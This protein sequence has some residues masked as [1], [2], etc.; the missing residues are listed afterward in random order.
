MNCFNTY[1]PDWF[2]KIGIGVTTMGREFVQLFDEWAPT[3]DDTVNGADIEYRDA[4]EGYDEI[5]QQVAKR[6]VGTVLEFGVGTGNLTAKLLK[7]GHQVFGVEPSSGMREIARKRYPKVTII[8]GDFIEF[9]RIDTTIHSIVSS[10][11]FHHLTDGEKNEAIRRYHDLLPARGH[12][13]FADT[14]F[15]GEF[16]KRRMISEAQDKQYLNLLH[17]LQTEYYTT[18]DVLAQ[19]FYE[20]GFSVSFSQCN[21]FVW[22][23]DAMKL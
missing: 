21:S 11:A 6:A 22:M 9:P 4:F 15:A 16:T 2:Y 23:I 19:T 5:L 20:H 17:D 7:A 10:Y 12:I 14:V 1:F 3:Y 8:D 18:V 13:V